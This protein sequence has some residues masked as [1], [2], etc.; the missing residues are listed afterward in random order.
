MVVEPRDVQLS[1]DKVKVKLGNNTSIDVED[2]GPLTVVFPNHAGGIMV[3][4]DEVASVSVLAII[5]FLLVA[6]HVRGVGFTT[7]DLDMSVTL[8]HERL[9]FKSDGSGSYG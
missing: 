2:Y 3:R 4:L 9:R 6:A 5:H 7:D 1:E 8:L